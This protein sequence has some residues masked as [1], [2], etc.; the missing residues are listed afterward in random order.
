MQRR[1]QSLTVE[2][3]KLEATEVELSRKVRGK[4]N[5]L[6][7]LD[8]KKRELQRAGSEQRSR[9]QQL[10]SLQMK[11]E[12]RQRECK[13]KEVQ[14]RQRE[15]DLKLAETRNER[16][17]SSVKKSQESLSAQQSKLRKDQ[18][19]FRDAMK[20]SELAKLENRLKRARSQAARQ[21]EEI[22]YWREFSAVI[23][24]M[25]SGLGD[26][27]LWPYEEG[28]V[29]VGNDPY[30]RAQMTRFLRGLGFSVEQPGHEE[31]RLLVV[32]RQKWS[33][34]Q[35]E[36]HIQ[37][38][39]GEELRVF[40]QEMFVMATA[41]A[42]DPFDECSETELLS[43]FG[44][45][46]PALEF[47]IGSD[48]EWPR[49]IPNVLSDRPSTFGVT[50]RERHAKLRQAFSGKLPFVDSDDYMR[51]WG[52]PKSPR[53]LWRMAHH[54]AYLARTQGQGK[55]VA[56]SHWSSD[57]QWLK[58]SFLRPWMQFRWPETH[59]PQDD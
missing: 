18:K 15:K 24:W 42:R 9:D 45:G 2:I 57:L 46:H 1:V 44:A 58:K 38:R 54:V 37:A 7:D 47:L 53:R 26:G 14:L 25:T 49:T 27:Q 28:V 34:E 30:P 51:E 23:E 59:V 16:L 52:R 20:K 8:E 29:V 32:G 21:K 55:H 40:S 17:L 5:K 41:L 35:L 3:E 43:L 13:E 6:N 11:L 39:Q 22:Q 31:T 56:G 19:K 48:L 4:E 50:T 36:K 33:E 12:K 10:S